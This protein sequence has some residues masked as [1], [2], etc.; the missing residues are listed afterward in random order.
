MTERKSGIGGNKVDHER[1]NNVRERARQSSMNKRE[2][3]RKEIARKIKI[4][5]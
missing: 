2:E 4:Y 3:V 1:E 5:V